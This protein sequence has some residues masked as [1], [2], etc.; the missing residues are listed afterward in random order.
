MRT[1]RFPTT[2]NRVRTKMSTVIAMEEVR[3]GLVKYSRTGEAPEEPLAEAV[4]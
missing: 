4:L 2:P 1:A 3:R